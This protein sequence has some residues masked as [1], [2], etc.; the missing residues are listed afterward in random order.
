MDD[1]G[2]ALN[3]VLDHINAV[4]RNHP[5]LLQVDQREA[6]GCRVAADHDIVEAC[7]QA[8]GLKLEVILVRPEPRHGVIFARVAGDGFCDERCL[9]VGV[10]DRLQPDRRPVGKAIGVGG[11]VASRSRSSAT[12]P[13]RPWSLPSNR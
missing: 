4:Q 2:A 13:T 3:I 1:E 12:R 5:A 7:R 8:N 11:A 6:A 9:V 10:L